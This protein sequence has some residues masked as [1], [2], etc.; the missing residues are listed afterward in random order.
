MIEAVSRHPAKQLKAAAR[1]FSYREHG[2]GE[3]LILLHGI[4][5]SS[6]SWVMFF[7]A[8]A[9]A[10]LIAWDAPGYGHSDRLA[11]EKP[12]VSEYAA[13]LEAMLDAFDIKRF[14]LVGHSLGALIATSFAAAHPERVAALV[15]ADPAAGYGAAT[16]EARL[17]MVEGRLRAI[18]ELGPKGMADQRSGHLLSGSAS[19]HARELVKWN[20][21]QVDPK[22]YEQAVQMLAAG[23]IAKDAA[24]YS[25]PVLVVCGSADSVTPEEG[26]RRVAAAFPNAQYRTLPGLGH[27]SYVESPQMVAQEITQFFDTLKTPS[28]AR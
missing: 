27:A 8:F 4:G 10:R 23:D 28:D 16:Q 19:K 13:A 20:M 11:G 1:S 3:P 5:S 25:G 24:R 7:D 17:K 9:G 21:S 2:A 18:R 26:C 14:R 6:A 15:L 22:G 12:S